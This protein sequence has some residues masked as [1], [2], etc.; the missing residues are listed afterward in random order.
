[1]KR[2]ESVLSAIDAFN[3]SDHN[4]EI[5]E[6][7]EVAK[8]V[9]YSKRMSAQLSVLD[10]QAS[11]HLQIA[12]RAQHIGRWKIARSEYPEGRSGYK[13]WR[14]DLAGL[15]ADLTADLMRT[16]GYPDPTI[17]RVRQLLRK[18]GIKS[19]AEVQTLEDC[20]CLVF[21]EYYLD[22]FVAK[23]QRAK[24]LDIIAKTWKKMSQR[25]QAQALKLPLADHLRELVTAA[26]T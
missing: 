24:V 8:E 2:L 18:Q 1:M 14:S 9:L 15:H 12:V 6:G 5:D 17:D 19:D 21:I 22:P 3:A 13:R 26:V 7:R 11:E 16:S 23:H 4:R 25:G 10:A 20:A